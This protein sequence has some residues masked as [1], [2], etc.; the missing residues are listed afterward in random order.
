MVSQKVT[1]SNP[2]GLHA[3]PAG[4]LAKVAAPFKSDIFIFAGEKKVQVKSVLSIMA[5][6]IK[7]G[8]EVEIQCSG[9]DEEAALKAIVEALEGGLGE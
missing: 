5:A 7:K 8:T 2:T 9:E 4:V 3:R 1:V 6:A